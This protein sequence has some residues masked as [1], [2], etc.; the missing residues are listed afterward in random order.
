MNGDVQTKKSILLTL[1]KSIT[2]LDKKLHIEESSWLTQ[3]RKEYPEIEAKFLKLEPTK[4][5]QIELG[6]KILE[7]VCSSWLGKKDSNR[8]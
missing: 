8:K 7:P 6:D 3:I 5:G 1:G 2:A 4:S